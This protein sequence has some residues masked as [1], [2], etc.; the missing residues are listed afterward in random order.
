MRF[1]FGQGRDYAPA[2]Q[3]PGELDRALRSAHRPLPPV[4]C[5]IA[6][7]QRAGEPSFREFAQPAFAQRFANLKNAPTSR[8]AQ[9]PKYP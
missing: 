4:M 5:W 9:P 7:P 8:L 1:P 3:F 6:P 2:A